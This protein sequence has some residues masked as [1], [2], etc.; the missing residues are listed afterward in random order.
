M[1]YKGKSLPNLFAV[2]DETEHAALKRPVAHAYST[3]ALL[4]LEPYVD[5]C[6]EL[7]IKRLEEVSESGQAAVDLGMWLQLYAFDV[8][9]E[10]TFSKKLGFLKQGGDIGDMLKTLDVCSSNLKYVYDK[11]DCFKSIQVYT[12]VV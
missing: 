1:A 3:T 9:G 12:A 4:E 11:A 5:T 6:S 10:I 8:I 2:R 7:F